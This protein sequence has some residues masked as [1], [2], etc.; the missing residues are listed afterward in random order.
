MDVQTKGRFQAWYP[1][2]F[3]LVLI[4]GMVLGF[5]LRDTLRLKRDISTVIQR[6][7][8]LEEI[9]DL[10]KE[11]YVDT[12][13]SNKLYEDA[14]AG[15]LQSL[16]PHT[17]YIPADELQDINDDLEGGFSGIGLEFSLV[18]DTIEVTGVVDN[19]P[20]SHAGI[21]VGDQILKVNDSIVA[22]KK[23]TS[24]RIVHMLKGRQQSQVLVS[25]RH[26]SGGP[27]KQLQLTRDIIPIHSVDAS[28]MLDDITGYIKIERFSATTHDEFVTALKSLKAKGAKQ[29]VI[30]LRD[31]PGG[32]IDAA[33]AIAD[34]LL[35]STRLIVYTKGTHSARLDYKAGE[36]GLF[37]K[38]KLAILVNEGSASA[39]E[40]LA[41]AV[42]D[43]DRG[44]VIGRRTFG[45]G[46]VQEQY[47]LPDGAALRLTIARYYTPS[48]RCIQRSF[49]NGR[50]AYH[51]DYEKRIDEGIH[52]QEDTS[53]PADT[54]IYRTSKHRVVY[55]GGG[56][57]PDVY[58]PYDTAL[59]AGNI[60]SLLY[61]PELRAAIWDYFI[62]N[63]AQLKY[64]N[65]ADF[66][67][68]FNFQDKVISDYL[69]AL[70]T[71]GRAAAI[72]V[73]SKAN[74]RDHFKVQI[75][76]Q[77]ARFLFHDNGYYTVSLAHD[78]AVTKA[79]GVL[80]GDRYLGYIGR[81]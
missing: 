1:L 5:N 57:K 17:V 27:V 47:D 20:A 15:I 18:R 36:A 66:N 55:G 4:V 39:S 76:A 30:D 54:V 7:D 31:N 73:L 10:V 45:K 11:K 32:Y 40:I 50:D 41:G 61:S 64:H 34:D 74:V 79:L 28:I 38:G 52:G 16:D 71:D 69:A 53:A 19:G 58:V 59:L 24:D 9:I 72:S 2:L 26:S 21:E 62:H 12:V 35:D 29:L 78:D 42:Q 48:G 80:N 8:R 81:Q 22:G 77:L 75:K 68:T 60:I 51:E 43:W 65:I 25:I 37:E 13:N 3:S 14:I 63:K 46:L 44:V 70:G 23:I 56:I 6:N 49:A 33:T 67:G